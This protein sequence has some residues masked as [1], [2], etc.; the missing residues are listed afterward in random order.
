MRTP[1]FTAHTPH[2][3]APRTKTL[4]QPALLSCLNCHSTTSVGGSNNSPL[5]ARLHG[6]L[7]LRRG[8]W[9]RGSSCSVGQGCNSRSA[10]FGTTEWSVARREGPNPNKFV[11]LNSASVPEPAGRS[12]VRQ[13]IDHTPAGLARRAV[14]GLLL[15]LRVQLQLPIRPT[16]MGSQISCGK[17]CTSR[18]TRTPL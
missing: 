12:C 2:A 9:L 4:S 18:N 14:M 8:L 11:G 7:A 3:H 5:I 10:L 6:I 17:M 1:Y 13:R 16:C 15:L